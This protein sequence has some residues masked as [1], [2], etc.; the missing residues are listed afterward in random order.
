MTGRAQG[1][2]ACQT[3]KKMSESIRRRVCATS[4]RLALTSTFIRPVSQVDGL[5][6]VLADQVLQQR[7][8]E[9]Q[10]QSTS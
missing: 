1:G 9:G 5:L 8:S 10:L 7:V 3:C 6:Q 4:L 2:G